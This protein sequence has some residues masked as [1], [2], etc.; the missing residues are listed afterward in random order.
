MSMVT[1][2]DGTPMEVIRDEQRIGRGL[3]SSVIE[4]EEAEAARFG[5]AWTTHTMHVGPGY[6]LMPVNATG[7]PVLALRNN[8]EDFLLKIARV[9]IL[10]DTAGALARFIWNPTVGTIAN[11]L[12]TVAPAD[13]ADLSNNF[14]SERP[15]PVDVWMW[16][17]TGAA[18][19][20]G[21]TYALGTQIHSGGLIGI[22]ENAFEL[23][24]GVILPTGKIGMLEITGV[25]SNVHI[26][27]RY[28]LKK[29]T[30]AA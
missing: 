27:V 15:A 10:S 14:G 5:R 23:N 7:G 8:S 20:T 28:Y 29:P 17:H 13:F 9:V 11:A 26:Q 4:T 30:V 24:G 6:G 16:D 21:W 22:G 1:A 2:P 3:V 18:A 25:A 19:M 12:S